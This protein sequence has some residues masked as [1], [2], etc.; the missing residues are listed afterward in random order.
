MSCHFLWNASAAQLDEEVK[1]LINVF[2]SAWARTCRRYL[3]AARRAPEFHSAL[4]FLLARTHTHTTYLCFNFVHLLAAGGH[5]VSGYVC[6][7]VVCITRFGRMYYMFLCKS[8]PELYVSQHPFT[9][10][11][12]Y[13]IF[14]WTNLRIH[15]NCSI[16]RASSYTR[17]FAVSTRE[18]SGGKLSF[19][20][21]RIP[22]T[23][24]TLTGMKSNV[25]PRFTK[26][27]FPTIIC[28]INHI[29]QQRQHY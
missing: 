24:R 8:I 5:W 1:N 19:S 7:S 29:L 4:G 14:Q 12:K 17:N 3:K 16:I 27:I 25:T 15:I 21:E 23:M 22:E 13:F 18:V 11:V 20:N 28:Y 9:K 6:V 2:V 26:C 10:Q